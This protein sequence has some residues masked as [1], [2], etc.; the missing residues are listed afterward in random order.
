MHDLRIFAF[1]DEADSTITGQIAVMKQHGLAGLEIRNVDGTNVADI[2]VEKAREVRK[3]LDDAGLSVWSVGS[4]IGKINIETDDFVA[5]VEKFKHTLELAD[6]LGAKNIRLFSF[7]M[8]EEKDPV[9]F[10]N[11][12]I[13]RMGTFGEVANNSDVVLCHENEK[14]I[15]GDTSARCLDIFRAVPAIRGVFDPANF[16]QCG[17]NP[18]NA[19]EQLH[20]YIHYMHIK[21]AK[22]SGDIVPAGTGAGQI[23]QLL[24]LYRAQGGSVITLEPHLSEFAG[25]GA[26]ERAGEKSQVGSLQFASQEEAFAAGVAALKT[27]L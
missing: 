1:A 13:D 2:T 27:I 25:L 17:E 3:Q 20:T 14:G 11:E 6:I 26:L 19:W 4:P 10:K 21:D 8:P 12:V 24:K 5:H 15:Y 7:Y 23:P 22:E 18:L 9:L 16:V